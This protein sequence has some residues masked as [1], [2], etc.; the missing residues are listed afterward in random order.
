MIRQLLSN[1]FASALE[2][3]RAFRSRCLTF[4]VAPLIRLGVPANV[5]TFLSLISGL[6]AVWF[7]FEDFW[8]FVLFGVLHLFFDAVDGVLARAEGPT[9]FGHYFDS[10]ADNLTT[11]LLVLKYA[12][13]FDSVFGFAAF[14][15]Y[16]LSMLVH[17]FSGLRAPAVFVRTLTL[18]LF[19]SQL[20]F[21]VP[22]VVGF[23][24]VWSLLLQLRHFFFS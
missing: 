20:S 1:P 9:L 10:V 24:G 5:L 13:A 15:V 8:L 22:L 17:W 3:S 4:F 2:R 14:G 19:F 6:A 18:F 23:V 11:A 12:F 21:L 7:L 16:L